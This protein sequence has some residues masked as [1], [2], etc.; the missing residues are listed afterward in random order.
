MIKRPQCFRVLKKHGLYEKKHFR[1]KSN[2]LHEVLRD[3]GIDPE[4]SIE[5]LLGEKPVKKV[6]KPRVKGTVVLNEPEYS[7]S[8][9]EDEE[10]DEDEE[11][12]EVKKVDTHEEKKVTEKQ[13]KKKLKK[14][15][16]KVLK[17][18]VEEKVEKKINNKDIEKTI[19]K[20]IKDFTKDVRELLLDFDDIEELDQFDEDTIV[21]EF[22]KMKVDVEN[23]I[24]DMLATS[25]VSDTFVEKQVERKLDLQIEKVKKFLEL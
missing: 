13:P 19:K 14:L 1:L 22:N 10:E 21:N 17:N 7:E 11:E 25:D 8:E 12:V 5:E 23:K 4:L 20:M 2:E 6:D 16:R 3:N 24:E 18:D 9:E 15:K